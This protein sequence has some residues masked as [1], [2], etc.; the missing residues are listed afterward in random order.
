MGTQASIDDLLN[1]S[2]IDLY[3][4]F[5]KDGWKHGKGRLIREDGE[6]YQGDWVIDKE[7]GHGKAL[8]HKGL[9][10]QGKWF[11]GKP[12]GKGLEM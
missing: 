3:E 11:Q 9:F 7:Q 6:M 4:G 2:F 8:D 12:H 10:Y 1:Y 5:W